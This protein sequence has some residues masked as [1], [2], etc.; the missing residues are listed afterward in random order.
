MTSPDFN[1][2]IAL[3]ALLDTGSVAGAAR[4]L[5]LSASAMSRT[6]QRL[7]DTTGDPLLVR[8]GRGLVPTPRALALR[9]RVGGLVQEVGQMLRPA[10]PLDLSTVRQRFTVL[11]S[12]GFVENF[13]AA[14]LARVA[15]EAPGIHLHFRPK[16]QRSNAP[17]REGAADLEI[18]VVGATTAPD[19]HARALFRDRFVAVVRAGHPLD[20]AG[21]TPTEY[22][23][24]RHV[25]DD[26]HAPAQDPVDGALSALGLAR[27]IVATVGGFAPALALV[28]DAGL[29][30]TVP[31]HH[32]RHLRQGL[33]VIPLPVALPDITVSML[34]PPRL[35][36]D[37]LHCWLRGVVHAVCAG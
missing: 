32:T 3:E 13:G 7:R 15:A 34:W 9:A 8:S 4:R 6:L 22:A 2:L 16:G 20:K 26:R 21:L 25:V 29:L 1:L 12:D 36:A 30:A 11:C 24:E 37:P 5:G 35:D 23:A 28:R 14:L 19:F 18:G 33:S 17:L 10:A 27:T 31:E